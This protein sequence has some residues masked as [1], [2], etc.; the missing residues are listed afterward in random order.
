MALLIGAGAAAGCGASP[1]EES[2]DGGSLFI[3]F[4]RDFRGFRGWASK[5]VDTTLAQG[6][7]HVSGPRTTYINELPPAGAPA[8]PVGTVIVKVTQ[9][10]GKIFARAKRGGTFNGT[11]AVGWEWFEIQETANDGIYIQ[12][13]GVGPG[14]GEKYGG[15]PNTT[16]NICHKAARSNDYVLSDWLSLGHAA[17]ADDGGAGDV[18]ATVDDGGAADGGVM[19]SDGATDDAL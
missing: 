16:C 7:T 1:A 8:F 4:A 14:N 18:D 9:A 17:A 15:D 2:T 11:G 13:R 12:W 6:A 19:A 5:T 10:D 3:A